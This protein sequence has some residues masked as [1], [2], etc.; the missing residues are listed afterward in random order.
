[1][2]AVRLKAGC[3]IGAFLLTVQPIAVQSARF[4]LAYDRFVVAP[5]IFAHKHDL[6]ARGEEMYLNFIHERR[7][8]SEPALA[9][10]RI[11][12]AQTDVVIQCPS[13]I[14]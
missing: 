10:A 12:S 11:G 9:S 7:P 8:H 3:R 2:H 6:F 13:P 14:N 1:M 5:R 4:Q